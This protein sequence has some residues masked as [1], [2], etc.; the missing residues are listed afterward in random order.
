VLNKQTPNKQIWWSSPVSGPIR[1]EW[2]DRDWVG[3]RDG[4]KLRELLEREVEDATG[5]QL[6]V[7]WE[8]IGL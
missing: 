2:V 4:V 3:T 6:E 7:E 5:G 8:D 1:F